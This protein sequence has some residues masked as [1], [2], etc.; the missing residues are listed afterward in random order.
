MVNKMRRKILVVEDDARTSDLIRIY[1]EHDGYVVVTAADG[2][3]GVTMARQTDN[4][5]GQ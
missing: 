3:Q 4:G 1:L 2:Q 5:E